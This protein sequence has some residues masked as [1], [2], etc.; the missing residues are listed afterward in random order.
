MVEAIREGEDH[1]RL[2]GFELQNRLRAIEHYREGKEKLCLLGA[3][4]PQIKQLVEL[5]VVYIESRHACLDRAIYNALKQRE[6]AINDL[7]HSIKHDL[8]V[9]S[10]EEL[11]YLL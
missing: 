3:Q 5:G 11:R 2:V 7:S 10:Q 4:D 9:L 6:K 8:V 1:L